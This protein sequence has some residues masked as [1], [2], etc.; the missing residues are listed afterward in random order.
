M[1]CIHVKEVERRWFGLA[2]AGEGIVATAAGSGKERTLGKLLRSIPVGVRHREVEE[3]SEF[4]EK[5]IA[6]LAQLESGN[7]EDKSFSLAAEYVPA[8]PSGCC[9]CSSSWMY[10]P[11]ES[12]ILM[13]PVTR[14]RNGRCSNFARRSKEGKGTAF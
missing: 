7:E 1:I 5:T 14:H 12:S 3:S 8:P 6:M 4:V 10:A 9:M 13:S 11:D 2:Y